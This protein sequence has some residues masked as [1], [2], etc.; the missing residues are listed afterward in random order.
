MD[1]ELEEGVLTVA[2]QLSN[3]GGRVEEGKPKS[4]ASEAAVALDSGTLAVLRAHRRRQLAEKPAWSG[5][6]KETGRIFTQ[7]DG[8]ALTPDWVS[9]HC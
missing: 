3:V 6:W 7:E 1:G 8:S 4:R 2:E 9:E 5:S